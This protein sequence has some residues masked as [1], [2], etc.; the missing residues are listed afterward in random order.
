[1]GQPLSFGPRGAGRR[2]GL[3]ARLGLRPFPGPRPGQA[4]GGARPL[5]PASLPRPLSP[6]SARARRG[7][8]GRGR[9]PPGRAGREG[10]EPGGKGLPSS[11]GGKVRAPREPGAQAKGERSFRAVWE[12]QEKVVKSESQQHNQKKKKKR[13]SLQ[14]SEEA[15]E[16]VGKLRAH[17]DGQKAPVQNW[18]RSSTG[19]GSVAGGGLLCL[20]RR[21]VRS[22][23]FE[24]HL[25]AKSLGPLGHSGSAL[26]VS[27][28]CLQGAGLGGGEEEFRSI[29]IP[30]FPGTNICCSRL[31]SFGASRWSLQVQLQPCQVPS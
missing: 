1:M 31:H 19:T 20:K 7:A 13:K 8:G 11:C 18:E 26:D 12:R 17:R 15:Q 27:F 14:M 21:G 4:G 25:L 29:A 28:S 24:N 22:S 30:S 10:G 23:G 2:W 6:N 9:E 3:G 16:T 5:Q